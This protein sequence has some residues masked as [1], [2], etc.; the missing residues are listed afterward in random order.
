M[1]LLRENKDVLLSVLE[2]FLRDPTVAWGRQGRAQR[3]ESAASARADVTFQDHDNADAK[4]ALEKITGRLSGIYNIY[5]PRYDD[6]IHAYEQRRENLPTKGICAS[7]EEMLPLSVQGQVQRL[8]EEAIAV[9]NLA[10]M[11]VGWQPYS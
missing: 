6:I 10:Q 9:E 8:I 2:P 11:Y 5:H 3:S 4:A 1:R 7:K